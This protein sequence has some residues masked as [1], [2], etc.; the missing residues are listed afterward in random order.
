MTKPTYTELVQTLLKRIEK[1]ESKQKLLERA[2]LKI[3]PETADKILS[4]KEIA[5]Y[6]GV[7]YDHVMRTLSKKA[8]FPKPIKPSSRPRFYASEVI[9]FLK[10][11]GANN[12]K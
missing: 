1:L 2:L 7:S 3:S 6:I 11:Q 4:Y 12:E 10:D 9:Q 5:Q 8:G